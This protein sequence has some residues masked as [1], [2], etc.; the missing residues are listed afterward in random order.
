MLT[1]KATIRKDFGRKNEKLRREG[2]FPAVLYGRKVRNT[3][4]ALK[5]KEFDDAYKEAGESSL[6]SLEVRGKDAGAPAENIV[7]IRD[8]VTHPITR[9]FLHVDFYQVPMDEELT[10][11]I[12]LEFENEAPAVR[13]EGAILVRNVYDLEVSALPKDLP[14][15]IAVDLSRLQHTGDAI[16]VKDLVVSSGVKIEAEDDLVVAQVSPPVEEEVVAEA[17]EK[18]APEAIKTEAEE[19]REEEAKKE[20]VE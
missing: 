5:Y 9:K 17:P 4:L 10:I 15:E 12:P 16:L 13:D 8:V 3:P 1:L 11:A 7:I 2:Y 19:K 18:L 6:I 20:V 14:R